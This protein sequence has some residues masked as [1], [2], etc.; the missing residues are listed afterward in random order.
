MEQLKNIFNFEYITNGDLIVINKEI[1]I[2]NNHIK[3]LNF[4]KKF[5]DNN[6]IIEFL[7]NFFEKGLSFLYS[8]M[9][10]SEINTFLKLY[11]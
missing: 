1:Y 5:Q 6:E 2:Q 7:G 3:Y 4:N 8:H 11:F 10:E 9:S